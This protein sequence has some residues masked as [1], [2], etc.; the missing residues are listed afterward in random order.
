MAMHLAAREND[1]EELQR[2]IVSGKHDIN[3]KDAM[4][5]TPLHIASWAGHAEIVEVLL[6]SKAKTDALANDNFTALHFAKNVATIKALVKS[7]KALVSARISKGNK[8]AL[9]LAVPKGNL[10][11]VLCL[12]DLGSDITAKTSNGQSCL[13][14]AKT[15]EMYAFIKE[16]MQSKIDKQQEAI[17]RKVRNTEETDACNQAMDDQMINQA[18]L[19]S[20]NDAND[21]QIHEYDKVTSPRFF[22]QSLLRF[23]HYSFSCL[24]AATEITLFDS[25]Y[26][27]YSFTVLP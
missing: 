7:N 9:H 23:V 12:I 3:E 27:S 22:C 8:T 20:N 26:Y 15:D 17:D 10:D 18:N 24:K 2:L 6:R 1:I 16:T 14:L 21:F 4:R 5:R 25:C 19:I 13:E 11:V